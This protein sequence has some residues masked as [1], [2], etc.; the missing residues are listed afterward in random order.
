[1]G[2]LSSW[3]MLALTHHL[4]VQLAAKRVGITGWFSHYAVL[5]DDVVIANEAVAKSYLVIMSDLGL[6]INL[7]K[8]ITSEI[9]V[10]EFAKRLIQFDTEFT[11]IRAKAALQALRTYNAIPPLVLDYL[12]KGFSPAQE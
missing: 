7:S 9:G 3:A 11:P 10:F 4:I 12:G 2:A 1:M 6:D 5:G 8:T